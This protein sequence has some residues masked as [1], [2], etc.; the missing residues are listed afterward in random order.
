MSHG[1]VACC[2]LT[3][4]KGWPWLTGDP[5]LPGSFSLVTSEHEIQK[6]CTSPVLNL[7]LKTKDHKFPAHFLSLISSFANLIILLLY[8]TYSDYTL[9]NKTQLA[10]RE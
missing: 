8:I 3:L 7:S 6:H 10:D 4:P 2:S 9:S 1:V 5:T